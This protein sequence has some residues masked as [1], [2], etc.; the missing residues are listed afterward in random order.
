MNRFSSLVNFICPLLAAI[1]LVVI[2]GS[3]LTGCTPSSRQVQAVAA[4][5]IARTTNSIIPSLVEAYDLDGQAAIVAASTRDEAEA[6]LQLV[7]MTWAPIWDSLHVFA[8]VHCAWATAV[9][10]G[11][12]SE[13]LLIEVRDAYCLLRSAAEKRVALPDY[14]ITSCDEVVP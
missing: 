4:D 13:Q 10:D 6:N 14:P 1:A 7:R 2:Y 11:T 5:T 12:P 3:G 9:E 8:K